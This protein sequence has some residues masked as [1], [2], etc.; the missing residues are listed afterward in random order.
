MQEDPAH[1]GHWSVH[2]ESDGADAIALSDLPQRASAVPTPRTD[3]ADLNAP[4][5]P[6]SKDFRAE[7]GITSRS[8]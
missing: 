5:I 7:V 3:Y 8:A 4:I 2:G 6:I 1:V